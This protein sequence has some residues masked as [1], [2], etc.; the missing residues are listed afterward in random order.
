MSTNK[1]PN[2]NMN[3]WTGTDNVKRVEFKENF[4]IVDKEVGQ[5]NYKKV[6]SGKDVNKLFTTEVWYLKGTNTKFRQFVLTG[7]SPMYATLTATEYQADGVTVAS[8]YPKTWTLAYDGDG[9][10]LSTTPN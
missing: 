7:T 6:K 10:L 2:L 5:Q 4:D 1:T 3:D 9:D 8:G